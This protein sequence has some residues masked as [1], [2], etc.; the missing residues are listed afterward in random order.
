MPTKK[1]VYLDS[2]LWR[3]EQLRGK[4]PLRSFPEL[5]NGNA[6][7]R[8][9]TTENPQ[10]APEFDVAETTDGFSLTAL[11]PAITAEQ[12]EVRV[13]AQLVIVSRKKE[14][15]ALRTTEL[16]ATLASPPVPFRRA[17]LLPT[18]VDARRVQVAIVDDVLTIELPKR[19]RPCA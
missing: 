12:I 1:T 10:V 3:R 4:D 19:S 13:T 16:E 14:T 11:V 18:A 15:A 8:S 7:G 17:F 5:F 6:S 9:V 2:G